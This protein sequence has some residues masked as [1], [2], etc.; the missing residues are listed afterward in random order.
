[1][2]NADTARERAQPVDAKQPVDERRMAAWIGKS[3]LVQGKVISTEDLTID[4]RVEGTIELG[5]HSLTIGVGAA[6]QADLV[7][8]TII[9]SGAV[10]GNVKASVKVDLRATGSVDEASPHPRPWRGRREGRGSREG[11]RREG[12]ARELSRVRAEPVLRFASPPSRKRP[13]PQRPVASVNQAAAR[14]RGRHGAAA[15]RM[16]WMRLTR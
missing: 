14:R 11:A 4:G 6:I 12:Y 9:I 1:M 3:L 7:A 13:R 10:T 2:W 8:Q 16:I 5:N 15:D